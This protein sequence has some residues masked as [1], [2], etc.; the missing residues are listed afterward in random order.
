[1]NRSVRI[2]IVVGT[3]LIM[4]IMTYIPPWREYYIQFR[5]PQPYI[6]KYAWLPT[7]AWYDQPPPSRAK[8]SGFSY[9]QTLLWIQMLVVGWAGASAAFGVRGLVTYGLMATGFLV[10]GYIPRILI[11]APKPHEGWDSPLILVFMGVTG[12]IGAGMGLAVAQALLAAF[13]NPRIAKT[14]HAR[15]S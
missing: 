11:P 9:D 6:V 12:L 8:N 15:S 2:A 10:C 3:L 14:R 13:C 1:M 4:V 7:Y 5:D